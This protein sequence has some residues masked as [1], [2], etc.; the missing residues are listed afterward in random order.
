MDALQVELCIKGL[1]GEKLINEARKRGAVLHSVRRD[2]GRGFILRCRRK[3]CAL[4]RGIAEEKGYAVEAARPVGLLRYLTGAGR[5]RGLLAGSLL[6]VGLAVY[7][8]GFV[9]QVR[10]ENAGAYAGEVRHFLM[11]Q[12]IRPGIRR[13]R[14]KLA[15][16]RDA[17]EW[18]LPEVKWVRASWEG[19]ALKISVEEGMPPP[20]VETEEIGRASCRERV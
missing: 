1:N 8:L 9:W 19:V 3:D 16:L 15:A 13:S 4:I 14:V 6:C 11:E 5:R 2:A 7:A 17:L 20:A 12:G 10:V 18:Y